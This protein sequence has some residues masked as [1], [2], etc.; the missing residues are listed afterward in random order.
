MYMYDTI[1][2]V[3]KKL[4]P[5]HI[6]YITC[7]RS[8]RSISDVWIQEVI[9]PFKKIENIYKSMYKCINRLLHLLALYQVYLKVLNHNVNQK[10]KM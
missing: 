2:N 9:I 1:R 4:I 3:K 5:M 10:R 6:K 8:G 7:P